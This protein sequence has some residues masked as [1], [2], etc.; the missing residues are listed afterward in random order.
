MVEIVMQITALTVAKIATRKMGY[1]QILEVFKLQ[2]YKEAI[3]FQ[4]EYIVNAPPVESP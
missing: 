1:L 4:G 2:N 3:A